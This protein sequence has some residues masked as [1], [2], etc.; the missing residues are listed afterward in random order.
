[1]KDVVS[2]FI[3][4]YSLPEP[5]PTRSQ[6]GAAFDHDCDARLCLPATQRPSEPQ[7]HFPRLFYYDANHEQ[8][9]RDRTQVLIGYASE[10]SLDSH[11]SES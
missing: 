6:R 10:F 7:A 3:F 2:L 4:S 8:T 5:K 1:M 9:V 11:A